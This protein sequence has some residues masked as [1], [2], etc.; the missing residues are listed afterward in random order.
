MVSINIQ[1]S[2]LSWRIKIYV[3]IINYEQNLNMV[4]VTVLE[5]RN[6]VKTSL[7]PCVQV[8]QPYDTQEHTF[9]FQH[10]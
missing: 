8:S 7:R 9:N 3:D 10:Q 4:S 1:N 5:E 2:P 6:S